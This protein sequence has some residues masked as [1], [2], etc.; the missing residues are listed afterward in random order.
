MIVQLLGAQEHID[1]RHF[2]QNDLSKLVDVLAGQAAAQVAAQLGITVNAV[3][4]AKARVLSR[5]HSELS[6]L[7]EPNTG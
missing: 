2:R 1:G 7:I 3:L 5:L 4:K 6:D